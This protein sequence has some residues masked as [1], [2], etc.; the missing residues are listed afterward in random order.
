MSLFFIYENDGI[1]YVIKGR[2]VDSLI[3][4]WEL[5][6]FI[7]P[8]IFASFPDHIMVELVTK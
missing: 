4:I 5:E 7:F 6:V 2:V 1:G 3:F 8:S